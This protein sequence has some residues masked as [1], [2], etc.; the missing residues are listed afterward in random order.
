VENRNP[1]EDE[2]QVFTKEHL[3]MCASEGRLLALDYYHTPNGGYR[4]PSEGKRFK[5]FGVKPGVPDWTFPFAG[6]IVKYLE[7]KIEKYR[8]HKYGGLSPSQVEF[9]DKFVSNGGKYRISYNPEE[10]V[11]NL[12]DLG[13]ISEKSP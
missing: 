5:H 13:V 9:R 3:D 1:T 7:L 6:G 10:I 11:R 4:T 2:L 8:N 12:I